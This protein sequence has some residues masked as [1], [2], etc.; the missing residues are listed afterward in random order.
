MNMASIFLR[1]RW[2]DGY[3]MSYKEVS[4]YGWHKVH[5]LPFNSR[6]NTVKLILSF[7]STILGEKPIESLLFAYAS[8]PS[9]FNAFAVVIELFLPLD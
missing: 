1:R 6:N 5:I 4:S 7:S 8:D 2:R 3:H 9:K